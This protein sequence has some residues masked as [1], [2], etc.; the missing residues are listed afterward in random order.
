MP[1]RVIGDAARLRQILLNLAGNA[2]KFT[3]SGGV[4]IAVE[5]SIGPHQVHFLIRDTGIG[6]PAEEQDRIFLEFEQADTESSRKFGGT[7]LGLA[8]SKRIIE[9]MGGAIAVESTPGAGSSFSL[10]LALPP[11]EERNAAPGQRPALADMDV[12]VVAPTPVAA[13]LVTRRLMDWGARTCLVADEQ[14]ANSLLHEREWSAVLVDRAMGAQ[15]CERLAGAMASI[16]RRIILLTPAE[17]QSIAQLKNAGFTGYLIKPVRADLLASQLGPA[18]QRSD[19][20]CEAPQADAAAVS[21]PAPGKG[22]AV[23]V[24]EDNEINALL[25]NALLTRLGHRP[26]VV[27]TGDAA[28]E[29]W[30]AARMTSES[31]DLLLMDLQ[32]PRGGGIEAVRRIRAIEA[33]E[34]G[35][36]LP[37]FALTAT[38]LDENRAACLAAGMDAFLVK[39]L[40]RRQLLQALAGVTPTA[41][42]AA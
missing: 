36:R 1:H 7:G 26:T 5:P 19:T 20:G 24:A 23:L 29:A 38:A 41:G 12:L 21:S 32:M 3:E 35:R 37:I 25:A 4:A 17:R 18:Q 30:L 16:E 42:L 28:V 9:R 14:V 27:G 8:I 33:Q 6:I 15:A 2:I 31:Y 10:S 34:G 22:L 39:P 40:D 13:S 11:A